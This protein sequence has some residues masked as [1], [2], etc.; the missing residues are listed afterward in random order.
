MK[1][2]KST[3][4]IERERDRKKERKREIEPKRER[5][6]GEPEGLARY[7]PTWEQSNKQV[8]HSVLRK[9][10]LRKRT[11]RTVTLSVFYFKPVRSKDKTF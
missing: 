4:E 5:E 2:S 7:H 6:V 8:I 1:K 9:F 3:Y 10:F 11:H